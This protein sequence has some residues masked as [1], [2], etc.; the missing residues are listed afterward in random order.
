LEGD[1]RGVLNAVGTLIDVSF[2]DLIA[3]HVRPSNRVQPPSTLAMT[4]G[5]YQFFQAEQIHRRHR[6]FPA[7]I[8]QDVCSTCAI[9]LWSS[10]FASLC[11]SVVLSSTISGREWVRY[12]DARKCATH[13]DESIYLHWF[14]VGL[15]SRL[16]K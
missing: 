7:T 6:P 10:A 15:V 4:G 14:V 9:C 1:A 11:A 2:A 13:Q 5:V 12:A 8:L 16:L 3:P